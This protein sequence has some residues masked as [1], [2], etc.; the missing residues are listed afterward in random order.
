MLN[1]VGKYGS[2]KGTG[3]VKR[4]GGT[5]AA[6]A[7]SELLALSSAGE[8]AAAG[9]LSDVAATAAVNNM[10]ALQEISD[11]DVRR[12]KLVQQG[13]HMLDSLEEL[14]HKLLIGAVP[15][16]TLQA[17]ERQMSIQKQSVT[18]P[19]L[20]ALIEEIEIRVAVELAKLERARRQI[21]D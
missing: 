12:H 4:K 6:G 7:F 13:R 16:A 14:R 11:E 10:L 15:A 17:L 20:T 1:K 9:A 21:I 5:A 18:D 8:T 2:V 3:G 19:K